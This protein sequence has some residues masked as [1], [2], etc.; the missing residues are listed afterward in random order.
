M[1]QNGKHFIQRLD[2]EL[3]RGTFHARHCTPLC[4][5]ELST[6]FREPCLPRVDRSSLHQGRWVT[7]RKGFGAAQ[8]SNKTILPPSL[9]MSFDR[10]CVQKEGGEARR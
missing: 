10:L 1:P 6:W 7:L 2:E 4:P 9:Y 5:P 8:C 3:H